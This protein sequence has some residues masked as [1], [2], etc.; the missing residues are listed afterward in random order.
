MGGIMEIEIDEKKYE[1]EII[2]K[3]NKNTY[4]RVKDGRIIVNTN[5]LTSKGSIIKLIEDNKKSVLKMITRDEKKS[6]REEN[7][8]Y[9]G[10]KYD[11]I[12]G[13]N[14][15]EITDNKIYVL[16]KKTMD[17]F[18]DNNIKNIYLE[19]LNY[20]YNLFEEK[21]PV[22]NLK[23][24]KMTSRWGVCNIKN[25]NITLNYQLCKYDM[26]CLDYVIVHELSHLVYPNHSSDFWNLVG[27][28]YPKY[29][30]CRKMLK[31]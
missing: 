4:V 13:F 21:I 26:C 10:K 7:F 2:R 19:R 31:E 23:I 6:N 14:E 17:K 18:I 16:D 1:V 22:P 11:V 20:W 5:Y 27:K 9:F 28:Y 15:M 12:Y 24:R 29:K 3:N 8:Y 30:E 25:H